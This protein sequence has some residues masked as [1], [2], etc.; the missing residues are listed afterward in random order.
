MSDSAFTAVDVS[1][2]VEDQFATMPVNTAERIRRNLVEPYLSERPWSYGPELFQCWI[3]VVDDKRSS[4]TGI[5]FCREGVGTPE[6]K[7]ILL[8]AVPD[9]GY[10][11]LGQDSSWFASL[12]A[13]FSDS[14]MSTDPDDN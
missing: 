4:G 8:W 7:W 10:E 2:I 3:V 1:K 6:L 14:F 12:E 13:A 9:S 11:H 5:A